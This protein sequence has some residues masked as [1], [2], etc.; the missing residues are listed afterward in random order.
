MVDEEQPNQ[1]A[2]SWLA[3]VRDLT[4][5]GHPWS[6]HALSVTVGWLCLWVAVEL[7]VVTLA[8]AAALATGQAAER[9]RRSQPEEGQ[10]A[11]AV[12]VQAGVVGLL[13]ASPL[14]GT[15]FAGGLLALVT[16]A[17]A[18]AVTAMVALR[19]KEPGAPTQGASFAAVSLIA[20]PLSCALGAVSL[21]AIATI[22]VAGAVVWLGATLAFTAGVAVA[23]GPIAGGPIAGRPVAGGPVARGPVARG[24]LRAALTRPLLGGIGAGSVAFCVCA[25]LIPPF[26]SS[27]LVPATVIAA[28][29][30][31]LGRLWGDQLAL[32]APGASA[33]QLAPL[34]SAMTLFA[35]AWLLL[36]L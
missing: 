33:V 19:A 15:Q 30:P 3:A 14:V 7:F 17:G 34:F 6:W 12:L 28:L 25:L 32:A 35:P 23:G 16:L 5:N 24:A 11:S 31:T 20:G 10:S 8:I 9:A 13:T 2:R 18:L 29:A 26:T 1:V 27:Q 4:S 36:L 21:S 22:S